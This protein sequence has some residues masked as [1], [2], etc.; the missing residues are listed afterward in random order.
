MTVFSQTQCCHKYGSSQSQLLADNKSHSKEIRGK[1]NVLWEDF[2]FERVYFT[3]IDLKFDNCI[4]Y[5]PVCGLNLASIIGFV[6]NDMTKMSTRQLMDQIPK[7]H[8]IS[9][10]SIQTHKKS[11]T[12]MFR[13]ILRFRQGL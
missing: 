3:C 12:L 2:R 5:S 9:E 1:L 6:L 13:P 11:T 4:A 10:A 8:T 7:Q